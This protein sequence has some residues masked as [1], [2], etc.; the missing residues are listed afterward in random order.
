MVRRVP[1]NWKW[2][3]PVESN[4]LYIQQGFHGDAV[5]HYGVV[6][7]G[8]QVGDYSYFDFWK[9]QANSCITIDEDASDILIEN[10]VR[11]MNL[12][13]ENTHLL[14]GASFDHYDDNIYDIHLLESFLQK[15]DRLAEMIQTKPQEFIRLYDTKEPYK[16]RLWNL[17]YLVYEEQGSISMWRVLRQNP[18]LERG[19]VT[20]NLWKIVNFY[21]SFC[22]AMRK[23][24]KDWPDSQK[25]IIAGP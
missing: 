20:E 25:F 23:M 14:E 22:R 10:F 9:M 3:E 19:F 5:T 11:D 15:F 13:N 2:R 6:P 7:V 18:E 24:R 4:P 21:K 12:K 1:S 17:L 8:Y 16:F